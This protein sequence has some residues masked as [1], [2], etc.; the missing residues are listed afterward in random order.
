MHYLETKPEG[1]GEI[2][3]WYEGGGGG[4]TLFPKLELECGGTGGG[5][6]E[7]RGGIGGGGGGTL[8]PKLYLHCGATGGG[9]V[10]PRG[11]IGGGGFVPLG[12]GN[13]GGEPEWYCLWAADV[14]K[15]TEA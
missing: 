11:G 14:E 10:E 9:G 8:Y 12:G 1:I 4:G 15:T 3:L 7:P 6:V 5:G 2:L 13:G